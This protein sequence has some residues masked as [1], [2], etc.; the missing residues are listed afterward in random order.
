[1][2]IQRRTLSSGLEVVYLKLP[3]SSVSLVVSVGVGF[4][5]ESEEYLGVSHLLEH[6]LFDGTKNYPSEFIFSEAAEKLGGDV[7]GTTDEYCT[8]FELR[9]ASDDFKEA[10]QLV[11]ELVQAPLLNKENVEKE[12]NIIKA[13]MLSKKDFLK[14]NPVKT[15]LYNYLDGFD[16]LDYLDQEIK[17][18]PSL[19]HEKVLTHFE[20]YYSPKN[21]V[22]GI[23]GNIE[24]PFDIIESAFSKNKESNLDRVIPKFNFPNAK[25]ERVK[26]KDE[27]SSVYFSWFGPGIFSTERAVFE[28]VAKIIAKGENGVVKAIRFDE[29][30]AYEVDAFLNADERKG[31]FIVSVKTSKEHMQKVEN[32]VKEKVA[33]VRSVSINEVEQAKKSVL[34][35]NILEMEDYLEVARVISNTELYKEKTP[36]EGL[37]EQI[38]KVTADDVKEFAEKYLKDNFVLITSK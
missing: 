35:E 20:K 23:V 16:Q 21:M 36:F 13:E 24:N 25:I 34:A 8:S 7:N 38:K 3:I 10:V 26:D 31:V 37:F 27:V 32:I 30:L 18:L 5:D 1:M 11:S 6:L 33:L 22:L 4:R 29:G 9:A 14:K 17:A 15:M 28:V 19:T 2:D 12:K